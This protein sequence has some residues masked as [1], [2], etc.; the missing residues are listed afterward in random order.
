MSKG[1]LPPPFGGTYVPG[2]PNIHFSVSDSPQVLK[3]IRAVSLLSVDRHPVY[4]PV[5][6]TA[7]P[8]MWSDWLSQRKLT[9][10]PHHAL[11]KLKYIVD[12]CE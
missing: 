3:N 9:V 11:T 2:G 7:I 8:T 5:G 1:A 6:L 4:V 12:V 10:C